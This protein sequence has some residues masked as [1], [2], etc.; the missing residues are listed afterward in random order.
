M[1]FDEEDTD[2]GRVRKHLEALSVHFDNVQIFASRVDLTEEKTVGVALGAGNWYAR[3]GQVLEW[4]TK[5][6]ESSRIEERDAE[7]QDD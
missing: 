5:C 6:N 3:H 4:L 2:V 1:A 7:D